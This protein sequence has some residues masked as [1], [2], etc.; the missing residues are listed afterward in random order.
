MQAIRDLLNRYDELNLKLCEDLPPDEME[1]VLDEQGKVQDRI[2]QTNAWELDSQLEQAMDAL[3]LPPADADSDD[4]VGRRAT[5][6]GAVPAAAERAGPAAARRA[7]EPSGRRV[8]G[9]AR[10]APGGVPGHGRRGDPRPLLP[11][12]RRRLDPR[13]RS[14]PRHPVGGQLLLVARAEAAPAGAGREGREQRQRTLQRELEW[15]RMSPRARQAK[16]KARLTAYEEL[17]N[18][19]TAQKIDTVEIY[20]PPG[21]RLGDVVVEARNLRKGYGD[22]LLMEDINFTLPRGGIVG[23]I[24]PN[25]AGK[26]TLFRMIIG[27]EKPDAGTLRVGETVQLGY[28]D[29]TRDALNARQD[30]LGGDHR[31]ARRSRDGQARGPGARLLLVVQLQGRQPAAEGRRAVGRRAQ[32]RCTWPSCSRPAATC[33][34]WTSPPTTSTSTRCARSRTRCSTSPAAPWSSATIAGSS[35]AS[36]RTSWRLK[37]TARSCG[38]RGTIRTTRRTASGA[39]ARRP[40]RPHRIKYR[41]LTR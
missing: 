29:Q 32:P 14:R 35:T 3:R 40:I 8:G 28:V 24:G 11:R 31:R 21:P 36:R 16:G 33:C 19:D 25:G 10:A 41:K 20:I 27:Q 18:Q 22:K 37:A 5:P 1:K 30:R 2:D 23:V 4:A 17:L 38:S 34:C 13:A 39:S 26:T 9:V 15:V 7:D 12:Q 6:R